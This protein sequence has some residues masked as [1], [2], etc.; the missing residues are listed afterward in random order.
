MSDYAALDHWLTTVLGLDRSPVAI[1]FPDAPP[2]G[3]PK[4]AGTQPSGCSF[5]RLAAAGAT[6]YT[7]PSDHYNCPVGSYTHGIPLPPDRENELGRTLTM[8]S[9]VGYIRMEE[10]PG[11]PRMPSTP[12]AIVY[13]PLS[14]TPLPPDVVL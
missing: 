10:V 14:A 9:D 13:A 2:A 8:M 12:A 7:V 4:F 5:W 6:F 11:V 1:A 3:V